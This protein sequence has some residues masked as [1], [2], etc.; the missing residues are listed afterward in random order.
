LLLEGFVLGLC[1]SLFVCVY[2]MLIGFVFILHVLW[3][4]SGFL[5]FFFLHACM[6]LLLSY[7]TRMMMMMK[8]LAMVFKFVHQ[9]SVQMLERMYLYI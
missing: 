1:F 3:H 8:I 7:G 9:L 6:L 5:L 2:K 4:I